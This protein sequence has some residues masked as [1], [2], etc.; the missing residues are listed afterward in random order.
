[1][2][3]I[4]SLVSTDSRNV[5]ERLRRSQC[6]KILES[7]KVSY[8][9]GATK[10]AM[11]KIMEGSGINPLKPGPY[12][13]GVK[14]VQVQVTD[15]DGKTRVEMYPE[16]RPHATLNKAINYDVEMEKILKERQAEEEKIA[17]KDQRIAELEEKIAFLMEQKT[18][19]NSINDIPETKS[20][21]SMPDYEA[22]EVEDLKAL[23][24][25]KGI[26]VHHMAG[27]KKTIEALKAG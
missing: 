10:D 25:E 24:K 1:M 3:H 15:E 9:S 7:Y 12:G 16:E 27:K 4:S 2:T 21:D 6:Y 18:A 20:A 19:S 14:Y 13:E 11:I 26:K 23:A 22:M 5:Y 17:E 8:P